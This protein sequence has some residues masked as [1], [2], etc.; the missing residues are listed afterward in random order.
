MCVPLSTR[1]YLCKLSDS[2]SLHRDTS[3]YTYSHV[4]LFPI[5][6]IDSLCYSTNALLS[7]KSRILPLSPS[8]TVLVPL[9]PVMI[10]ALNLTRSVY[11]SVFSDHDLSPQ[12]KLNFFRQQMF[13][14]F[15]LHKILTSS[16]I[17]I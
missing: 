9:N 13:L 1:I 8:L 3:Q 5:C 11:P 6:H 2:I 4:R 17:G 12:S 16:L 14:Y 7:A 10:D 15:H